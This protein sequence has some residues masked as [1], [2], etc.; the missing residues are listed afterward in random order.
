MRTT[1]QALVIALECL[2]EFMYGDGLSE[3]N[4]LRALDLFM[5]FLPHEYA[6]EDVSEWRTTGPYWPGTEP[7]VGSELR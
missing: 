6:A 5:E 2:K 7:A 4:Q 3:A 1:E